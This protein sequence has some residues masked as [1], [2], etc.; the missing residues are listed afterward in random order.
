MPSAPNLPGL[1]SRRRPTLLAA[2][3]LAAVI[4]AGAHPAASS[5]AEDRLLK[6]PP[7]KI[8][9][10]NGLPLIFHRDEASATSVL[11]LLFQG[12]RREDPPGKEGTAFLTTRLC[13]EFPDEKSLQRMMNQAT[14]MAMFGRQDFTLIRICC[15]TENLEEAL[16]LQFRILLDPLFSGLRIGGIKEQMNRQRKQ[17]EDD[18]VTAAHWKAL[19]KAFSPAP[20]AGPVLGSEASVQAIK[21]KDVER[22]YE[23]HFQAKRMIT[24]LSTDLP[25]EEALA[26]VKPY[27]EKIPAGDAAREMSLSLP[28]FEPESLSIKKDSLQSV[29]YMAFPLPE[30]DRRN[31]VLAVMLEHLLGKGAYSR[32]WPLREEKKLAY[33][34]NARAFMMK[35]GGLF[36]V[37]LET[38]P[39]RAEGALQALK[40]L[41]REIHTRGISEEEMETARAYSKGVV[42]RD[43]ETKEA[44]TRGLAEMEALGLGAD[45]LDVLPAALEAVTAEEFTAFLREVIRPDAGLEIVVGPQRETP[46]KKDRPSRMR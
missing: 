19:E 6:S 34:V 36:E 42:L 33:N 12:G 23:E 46:G 27:L 32:L 37:Y 13:L 21:K 14:S 31:Y 22:F 7:E 3:L 11:C 41:L 26:V 43:N 30:A 20:Y 5:P 4:L 35:E 28:A 45:F 16:R 1:S 8:L 38:D 9:L 18:P 15:L 39:A 10:S 40:D 24:A 2:A 29:V 25:R 17:Q 44:A